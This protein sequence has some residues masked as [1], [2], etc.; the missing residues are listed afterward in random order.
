MIFI[1]LEKDTTI[2]I[3][4]LVIRSEEVKTKQQLLGTLNCGVSSEEE[5]VYLVVVTGNW[6]NPT[7]CLSFTLTNSGSG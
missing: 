7:F 4:E 1:Y 2:G 5:V 6:S 3:A